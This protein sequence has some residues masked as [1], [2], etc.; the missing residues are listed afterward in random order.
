MGPVVKNLSALQ[1]IQV[2][3]LG[4]EHALEKGMATRSS[5]LAWRIPWTLST[6]KLMLLNCGVGEDS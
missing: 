3:F 6:E 2:Q 5:I 1:E 4:Q